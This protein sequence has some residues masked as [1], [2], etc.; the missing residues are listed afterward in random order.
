MREPQ[1]GDTNL[2]TLHGERARWEISQPIPPAIRE[3]LPDISPMLCHVLY[4]RGYRTPESIEAFFTQGTISHDPFLLPDMDPAVVRLT[5]AIEKRETVAIYGDFDCDGITAAAILA[6]ILSGL[7]LDPLVH[8]PE[9]AEGHGL[10]PEALAAFADRRVTLLITADCGIT[11][12][13]EVQ[14]AQ[15]MGMDVIIT[16]HH[17]PRPDGALPACIVVS[18]TRQDAVYPFRSLCGVGV[19]Y[20][21]LQALAQRIPS[22][23]DL[24][25]LLDLVALGTVA[26]VVPLVDENRSLVLQGLRRLQRTQRP[27]LLALFSAAGVDR[28][29]IDPTSVSYYLAPRIN[30]ANRMA[31][32]QLAYDLMTATDPDVAEQLATQLSSLNQQRQLLVAEKFEEIA[33]QIGPPVQIHNEIQEGRRAPL[34]LVLGEWPAGVSGLLASRLL[35]TYGL[36]AFV[37][38]DTGDGPL[39]VSARGGPDTHIDEILEGCETSVPGGVFLGYGGHARAAGFRVERD[40]LPLVRDLLQ[41]QARQQVRVDEIGSVLSIDAEVRLSALT[42]HAARQVK[43]L[44]PFGTGFP[45]PLFLARNV[46]LARRSPV[47][48]GKHARFA[49]R[50]GDTLIDGIYFG[51]SPAFLALPLESRLDI[52]FHLQLNERGGLIRQELCLRDW[53]A[54]AGPSS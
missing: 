37:G 44:A 27:G 7:G 41:E 11:A 18:P 32:P 13:E 23:P 22:V 42:L 31:T 45:E 43:S 2:T 9:R 21:L 46:V 28:G 47:S 52:V 4:C 38:S 8:V 20:K 14:V 3:C 51:T 29:R 17:E 49:A 25:A 24:T 39:T 33:E 30:A 26:D 54:A 10:H 35:E 19:A 40:R 6:E 15:G 50:S 36:P 1:H 53:H 5:R 34:L 16:D 12:L 48:D